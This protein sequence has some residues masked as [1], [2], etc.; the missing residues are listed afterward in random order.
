MITA[1]HIKDAAHSRANGTSL[2]GYIDIDYMELE[3]TFGM[4][5]TDKDT[6]QYKVDAEWN[7]E[8]TD[9]D[10]EYTGFCTIYNYKTGEHYLG[11]NGTSITNIRD[12]HVGGRDRRDA[13]LLEEF[14]AHNGIAVCVSR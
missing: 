7:I 1:K 2:I 4:P 12:W 14:L 8:F 11:E 3:N 5:Y 9:E 6:D 13:N 10:G